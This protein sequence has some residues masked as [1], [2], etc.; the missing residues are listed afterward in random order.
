LAGPWFRQIEP[1]QWKALF[2][3]Q[4]GWMLDAMDFVIYLM[5]IPTL[6]KVFKFETDTAGLLATVALLTSSVGGVLFG[7]VADRIGR[8]RA[9]TITI[10]LYSLCSLGT[11]SAGSITQLLIWRALLGLGMGGEWSAGAALVSESWPD[12]HRG[13]AVSIMQSGW[14]LGYILAAVLAA[15]ILPSWRW[16]CWFSG[17][18]GKCPNRLCGCIGA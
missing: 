4:A 13:K 5:A 12:A 18:C 2:A 10:L 9:L 7:V 14:A 15:L 16:L 3:A 1:R 11:A 17:S 8:T 6:Q